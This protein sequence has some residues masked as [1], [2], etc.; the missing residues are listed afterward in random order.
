[1]DIKCQ[2][3]RFDSKMY[4]G[5]ENLHGEKDLH[6]LRISIVP[7]WTD[8]ENVVP[9]EDPDR[10]WDCIYSDHFCTRGISKAPLRENCSVRIRTIHTLR[11]EQ[12]DALLA[13]RHREPAIAVSVKIV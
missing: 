5:V 4:Q 10:T 1:M 3:A 9:L 12:A 7:A 6:T 2:E 8:M 13:G 11:P